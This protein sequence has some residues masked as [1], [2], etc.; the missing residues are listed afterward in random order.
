MYDYGLND[1]VKKGR[2][3]GR[4]EGLKKGL[5]KGLE[6]GKEIEKIEIA[7]AL[8]DILDTETIAKKTG[9]TIKAVQALKN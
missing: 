8:L 1:G 5:E 7:I 3:E 4:E 9:L 2:E 6:K